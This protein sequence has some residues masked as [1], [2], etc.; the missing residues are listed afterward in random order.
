MNTNSLNNK[1]LRNKGMTLVELMVVLAIFFI[2]AGLTIF[3]Y[4]RFRS[5]VSLQNLSDDIAL[6]VRR[7]Q[8][9]A[10]GVHSSGSSVFSNGY[11]IHFSTAAPSGTDARAGST[12]T[13]MI[14][15]DL[16]N[17]KIYDYLTNESTV[18][19]NTTLASGDECI[20]ML[21]IT[22]TD[23]I[24]DICPDGVCMSNPATLDIT[25]L[26]PNPDATICVNGSCSSSRSVD[27]KVQNS[28]SGET[29]IISVSN[30]GQIGIR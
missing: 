9:Y 21:N 10:I 13:F 15:S 12:K 18:C 24:S 2:V 16:D 11:G 7:A 20:D 25:F 3:D 27:I 17:D 1:I 30:V 14:F 22:S 29:K 5:N 8:N 26:R 6:S 4:G 28:Q 19:N 23:V